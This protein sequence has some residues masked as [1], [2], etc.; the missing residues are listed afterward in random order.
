MSCDP[1]PDLCTRYVVLR[2]A[3]I[4]TS[5]LLTVA[6]DRLRSSL[7]WRPTRYPQ[8]VEYDMGTGFDGPTPHSPGGTVNTAVQEM[9]YWDRVGL[10]TGTPPP[11]AMLA[12]RRAMESTRNGVVVAISG[13]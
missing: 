12:V 7:H 6:E 4:S 9:H 5:A 1:T 2:P 11:R 3:G 8:V 13:G 10:T